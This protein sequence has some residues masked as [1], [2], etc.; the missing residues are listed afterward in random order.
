MCFLCSVPVPLCK[1]GRRGVSH[2]MEARQ[3]TR[4]YNLVVDEAIDNM[5]RRV[6]IIL[7]CLAAA[8]ALWGAQGPAQRIVA[9][10]DIH[11]DFDAL[12][13]ILQRTRLIDPTLRWSGA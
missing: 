6:C 10:G 2:T 5:T 13:G 11:G 1:A 12:V 3:K 7:V 4:K 9:I 8:V